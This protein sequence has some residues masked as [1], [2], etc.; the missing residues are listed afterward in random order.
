[1]LNTVT[2]QFCYSD[3]LSK[4][5][6]LKDIGGLKS[7]NFHNFQKS[8]SRLILNFCKLLKIILHNL[9]SSTYKSC[10]VLQALHLC[11]MDF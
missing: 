2:L 4:A 6:G 1:M 10:S 11:Y 5:H 7:T 3:L 9:E 8:K